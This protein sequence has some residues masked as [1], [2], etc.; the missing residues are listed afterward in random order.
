MFRV[1]TGGTGSWLSRYSAGGVS[2]HLETAPDLDGPW[3]TDVDQFDPRPSVEALADG[4]T[5]LGVPILVDSQRRTQFY[6]LRL[7]LP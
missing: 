3:V 2:Y 5:W 7:S 6:R 4:T 1:W